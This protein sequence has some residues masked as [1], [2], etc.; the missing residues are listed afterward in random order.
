[1]D[2]RA[3]NKYPAGALS[4]FAAYT[5]VIDGIVCSSME[6]FLQSLKFKSPEMQVEICKLIGMNAKRRGYGK[7][8]WKRQT[9]WWQGQP[10]NRHSEGYQT[11]ITRAYDMLFEQSEKFKKALSA[12]GKDATFTHSTGKSKETETILTEREFCS[13]LMRLKNK[14]ND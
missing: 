4:N 5:F 11:L 9:L 10:V 7:N 14:L 2:I 8:W 3:G 13:Q 6:G 12:A 1:M